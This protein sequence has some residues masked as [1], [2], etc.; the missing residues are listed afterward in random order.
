[1]G[2]DPEKKD[3]EDERSRDYSGEPVN[4]LMMRDD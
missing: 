4:S 1:M 2:N 3:G